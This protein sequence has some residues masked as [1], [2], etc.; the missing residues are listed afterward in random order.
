[1]RTTFSDITTCSDASETGGA[2][3][4]SKQLSPQGCDLTEHLESPVNSGITSSILVV[5]C[6]NG[7]GGAFR[8]YDVAGVQ[9][10]GLIS[11]EIDAA[12]RRVVRVTWPHAIEVTDIRLVTEQMVKEWAN[13]FP[14]AR[15]V[16]IWGGFPCVHLSSARANRLNLEGEGSNLFFDLVRVVRL[17]EQC[18]QGFAQVEF[19]IENVFSMDVSARQQISTYLDVKP[20]KLDPA[21]CT[22]MSRPRLA[23]VSTEVLAGPGVTLIDQGDFVEVQMTAT[24]PPNSSWLRPGWRPT[25]E[26]VIYPTFMKSI[27]RERPPPKPAGINRCSD[28]ALAR[29]TSDSFRFPPYQFQHKYLLFNAL[30]DLRYLGVDE[31]ELLMGMGAESTRF[32]FSASHQ[33][34]NPRDYWDKRYSLL[35]DGFAVL[36][37][38]WIAGQLCRDLV[39]PC[40]PQQIF[41][42]LGLAPGFCVSPQTEIPLSR[43]AGF[44][45]PQS[46]YSPSELTALISRQVAQNGADVCISLGTPFQNK[47]TNHS[48]LRA[49]W[50][51]WKILYS[52]HW[53]FSA[54]INSLE[55]RMILQT[56]LWRTRHE[57]EFSKRWLHL[58]D[59]MVCNY[60]LSKGRTSSR[61]LQPLVRQIGAVLLGTNSTPLYGHVDSCENPTDEASREWNVFV[62]QICRR[63][64]T[65]SYWDNSS[66]LWN[67]FADPATVPPRPVTYFAFP[68]RSEWSW[69]PEQCVW[70]MGGSTMGMWRPARAHWR[71]SVRPTILLAWHQTQA[72]R[73]LETLP[74][75]AQ[76]RSPY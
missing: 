75:L 63:T 66:R 12:A 50:W 45:C 18:F 37:F 53:H 42:R 67:H 73:G 14:R 20:L 62:W 51:N 34:A 26:G 59:S 5:S 31:R 60:I 69:P 30:G 33:K 39:S 68:R 1:M 11:I 19:V 70:R 40:T 23:W 36:S 8:C 61:M 57:S 2:V 9:P 38:A 65:S 35:G 16:H 13:A 25:E 41:N 7:I 6:F 49:G 22:P 72:S 48:S 55:M 17:V 43:V 24:F 64:E 56:V 46:F 58:A 27:P 3:A 29:W 15:A 52:T 47:G 32:C 74:H 21:D 71:L 10:L 28:Q 76:N 4:I 54:H 44:G